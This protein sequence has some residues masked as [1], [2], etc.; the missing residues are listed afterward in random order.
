RSQERGRKDNY[1]QGS[2]AEEKT[3]KALMVKDGVG[4][5]VVPPSAA[6]LYLSPKKDLSWTGL[7][8]FVD[9]T[10]TDYSRPMPT[11]ES[12]S[13]ESQNKHS[14][15]SKD[16]ASPITP[17][18][19]VKFVKPKD[20]QSEKNRKETPKKSQ[21]KYAEQYRQSIKKPNKAC[22]N[23][24]DF[25]HLANDCRKMVQKE[26]TRSA[27]H[28][29]HGAPMRPSHRP[30]GHR[31]HGPS[32]NPMRPN[33]NGARPNISFFI[34]AHSYETRPFLKTSAVKTQYRAPWVPAGNRNIPPVNRKFSTR[35]RNFP[36]ANRKF[37]T[38]S[39]KIHTADM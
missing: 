21:V 19:F 30:D 10:V 36:P 29:P 15:T 3:P 37:L 39:T 24:G 22:F 1:R 20:T 17:K 4:Y 28:I 8:K 13:E 7:L 33:M 18:L 38:S 27:G 35:R 25:F 26:T 11:V 31:P 2:K 16:V 34:Q 5:N 14:S 6:D 12:T 9:D 32:M 23:C